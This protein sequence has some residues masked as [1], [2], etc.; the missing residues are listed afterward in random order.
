MSRRFGA[1]RGDGST[2]N[3]TR[4][5]RISWLLSTC[6]GGRSTR[7]FSF[8]EPR[9]L[10]AAVLSPG[11]DGIQ[12]EPL[13]LNG[14]PGAD[15]RCRSPER[16]RLGFRTRPE[17]P[18]TLAFGVSA[19]PSAGFLQRISSPGSRKFLIMGILLRAGLG[20]KSKRDGRDGFPRD[21]MN[22]PSC[23]RP[24]IKYSLGSHSPNPLA[25]I[26][27]GPVKPSDSARSE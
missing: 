4:R 24:L 22:R 8:I 3:S 15:L 6:T 19:S 12:Q 14:R 11:A 25:D 7:L 23:G 2:A 17:C 18:L 9:K 27:H 1:L 26:D 13:G 21:F 16:R 20:R 10:D 5:R